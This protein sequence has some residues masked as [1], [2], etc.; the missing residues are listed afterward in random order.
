MGAKE[1]VEWQTETPA[2]GGHNFTWTDHVVCELPEVAFVRIELRGTNDSY[3]GLAEAKEHR[4]KKINCVFGG[5]GNSNFYPA[6]V[7]QGDDW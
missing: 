4:S 5:G 7:N 2:V 3:V 1:V 6:Y